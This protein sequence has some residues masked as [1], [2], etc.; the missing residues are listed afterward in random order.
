MIEI[1][2]VGALTVRLALESGNF[3]HGMQRLNR[4][5]RKA[6]S[7][8]KNS[9]SKM[10][11]LGGETDRLTSQSKLL[12]KQVEIQSKILEANKSK[13][14]DSKK[15]LESNVKAQEVLKD[16]IDKTKK[17]LEE[18]KKSTGNN[19]NETKELENKLKDLNSQYE[20]NNEK[21]R[22]AARSMDNW[23]MKTLSA[24]TKLN[25]LTNTLKRT[26]NEIE[27]QSSNWMKASKSLDHV[28]KKT[29]ELGDKTSKLGGSLTLGL[30]APL[31]ALGGIST[32]AAIS[33]ESAF[34]GVK[35]TIDATPKKLKEIEEGIISLSTT[36]IPSTA[37]EISAI[38]ESAG[39]LGIETNNILGFTKVIADLG[40]ATNL[41]GEQGASELAKFANITSMAQSNF[42]RLGSTIVDLGNN[43]ATTESDIVSMGL[44]LA[45]TGHLIGLNEAQILSFGGAMSSV[46][47]NAEAG[48]SSMSRV[49]Q[50]IN[51][52]VLSSGKHLNDFA[53]IANMSAEEFSKAWKSDPSVVMVN[54]LKGLDDIKTNGK[55]VTT[56]LKDLDISSTQEIDT[57]N[58][59][60]GAYDVLS[61]SLKIGSKAWKE[62]TAL[63]EEASQR[64]ATT[65]SQIAMTKNQLRESARQ[66]GLDLLPVVKDLSVHISNVSRKFAELDPNIRSNIVQTGLLVGAIGP[67]LMLG[68]KIISGIGTVAGG[69]ASLSSKMALASLGTTGLTST[70]AAALGPIGLTVGTV[71]A[72]GLAYASLNRYMNQSVIELDGFGDIVTAENEKAINSFK[73]LEN[74]ATSSLQSLA[75][76]GKEITEEGVLEVTENFNAM[77][78]N[79]I[80]ALTQQKDESINSLNDFFEA[81]NTLSEEEKVRILD[82]VNKRYE[83]E[84]SEHENGQKRI[85][86]ILKQVSDENRKLTEEEKNEIIRIKSEMNEDILEVY[87]D[88]A[89]ELAALKERIQAEDKKMEAEN[90][91]ELIKE[92]IATKNEMIKNA[93]DM[94][95]EQLK[96]VAKIRKEGTKEANDD[97]NLLLDKAKEQ[98]EDMIREAEMMNRGVVNELKKQYGEHLNIIDTSTGE[99]KTKWQLMSEDIDSNVNKINKSTEKLTNK[100]QDSFSKILHSMSEKL[101]KGYDD[102][103]KKTEDKK[104]QIKRVNEQLAKDIESSY[105]T[106]PNELEVVGNNAMDGFNKGLKAKQS[107]IRVTARETGNIFE[108]E[109]RAALDTHS[110]SKKTEAIGKDTG[111][112]FII[113]LDKTQKQIEIKAIEIAKTTLGSLEKEFENM[114]TMKIPNNI[115]KGQTQ[116]AMSTKNLKDYDSFLNTL[117]SDELEET[118]KILDKEYKIKETALNREIRGLT[119]KKNKSRREQLVKQKDSLR[120]LNLNLKEMLEERLSITKE[121]IEKESNIFKDRMTQYDESIKRLSI[122]SDDLEISLTNQNAIYILQSDR[123]K[124]LEAQQEKVTKQFGATSTEAINL[125]KELEKARTEYIKYG[126]DIV[127]TESKIRKEQIKTIDN[128]NTSIISGLKKKYQEQH[129]LLSK[130]VGNELKELESWKNRSITA[131]NDVYNAKIKAIDISSKRQIE[132]LRNELEALE[133][134]DLEDSRKK[135]KLNKEES[136]KNLKNA[137]EFEHNEYN[138][139]ELEKQ[140]SQETSELKELLNKWELEDKKSKLNKEI[141]EIQD[142]ANK[143]KEILIQQQQ[144]EI[145]RINTVYEYEK[146][147]LDKQLENHKIYL[148]EKTNE[149]ALQAE[150]EKLIIDNKQSDIIDILK[151]YEPSYFSLGKSFGEKLLDGMKPS[152]E[153]INEMI[154]SIGRVDALDL[155]D[156]KKSTGYDKQVIDKSSKTKNEIQLN[157]NSPRQMNYREAQ[158]EAEKNLRRLGW[159]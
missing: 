119:G 145:Y 147:R 82:R 118:K 65:E 67:V 2:D 134:S 54:F 78:D 39:Q 33:V 48:G 55:D 136:I 18:I 27:V 114:P 22:N 71:G 46:G 6:Q 68:G 1:E 52:Q 87:S 63:S 56:T 58:R 129:N 139:A 156:T 26:N 86:E 150:A 100:S 110:P 40:N 141:Q 69:L 90:T 16:S 123:L 89:L 108:K 138:K 106:L 126:E 102:L 84:V 131:I 85:T 97:A 49:W 122:S 44:R 24:D 77:K 20:N 112:G 8:F 113:G 104:P 146:D 59:L 57:L 144:D 13:F 111:A 42:D 7:E 103:R 28:S 74:E 154:A 14:E 94:Y 64:Y 105:D 75:L 60:S 92:S 98:R 80:D 107:L 155:G 72:L 53:K 4:D 88:N 12:N 99:I 41:A 30:T 151:K 91:A 83:E 34:A 140:L 120:D 76:T 153:K 70:I 32:K 50:K 38:A 5:M 31:M 128:L 61:E 96:V 62:N 15:T 116:K 47:I 117:K 101:G 35:K 43:L 79:V 152:I 93:E 137:I 25:N 125:R 66:I 159:V 149:V 135:E 45:G 9:A 36:E 11:G 51:T 73:E 143:E 133:K 115:L 124:E 29:T 121:N 3:Q 158:R 148:E 157:F 109:L 130:S 142:K 19:S 37:E 95:N 21:I 81:N 127:S 132:A 23:E 17:S 10:Q